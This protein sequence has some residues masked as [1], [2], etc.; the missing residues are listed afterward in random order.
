MD[1]DHANAGDLSMKLISPSK[2]QKVIQ[3]PNSRKIP[4]RPVTDLDISADFIDNSRENCDFV[5]EVCR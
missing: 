3:R 2:K 4:F 5:D 1:I